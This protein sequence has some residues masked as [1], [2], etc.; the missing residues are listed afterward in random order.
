MISLFKKQIKNAN[1]PSEIIIGSESSD[2]SVDAR[3]GK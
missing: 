2:L 1:V 3:G